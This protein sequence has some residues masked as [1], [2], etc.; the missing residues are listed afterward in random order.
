MNALS[1]PQE[2]SKEWT[3]TVST[4]NVLASAISQGKRIK[5]VQIGK[6]E[7][8]LSLLT[9]GMIVYI[10]KKKIQIIYQ[11]KKKSGTNHGVKQGHRIHGKLENIN[12]VSVY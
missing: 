4:A 6:E 3:Y 7:I 8:K 11:K 1:S 5:D 10:K 2:W 9:G 12:D